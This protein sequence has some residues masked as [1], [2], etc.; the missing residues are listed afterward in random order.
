MT[1]PT[2]KPS[3]TAEQLSAHI[4]RDISACDA[5]LQLLAA[6]RQAAQD[7][8]LN[9][10]EDVIRQKSSNLKIL[11]DGARTR[12][13]WLKS[14][15]VPAQ[16]SQEE[17]W[18]TLLGRYPVEVLASWQRLRALFVEC[19]IQNEVNG[20]IL[21]RKQKTYSEML[22]LVRGQPNGSK[23]YT[24]KG[25]ARQTQLGQDLGKA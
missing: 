17:Q 15:A 21:A 13:R 14:Q 1:A 20:K 18:L 3:L 11:E 6:E 8:Q 16:Q 19:Q 24:Q 10:L 22:G 9:L 25:A 7:R 2:S 12:A 23:L 5:L 4:E